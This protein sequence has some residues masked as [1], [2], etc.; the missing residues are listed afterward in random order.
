MRATFT[1][2]QPRNG[3]MLDKEQ[4]R[5][6]AVIAPNARPREQQVVTA[7]I[8]K[9]RGK[10]ASASYAS[11]WISAPKHFRSGHAKATGWGYDRVSSALDGALQSAGVILDEPL[12][13][14]GEPAM[15]EAL[16]AVGRALG[17]R[18]LILVSD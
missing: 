11:V 8:W 9:S 4:V 13:G 10:G 1:K 18:R 12:A 6:L 16:L 7:R 17:Y 3:R 5:F 2:D 15:R 14:L